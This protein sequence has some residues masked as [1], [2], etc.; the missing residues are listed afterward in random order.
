MHLR[1]PPFLCWLCEMDHPLDV[2]CWA[3]GKQDS[4]NSSY[5]PEDVTEKRMV[6]YI[7]FFCGLRVYHVLRGLS[8]NLVEVV[9]LSNGILLNLQ[10]PPL[11]LHL[12]SPHDLQS[13]RCLITLKALI[14]WLLVH[15]LK[16]NESSWRLQITCLLKTAKEWLINI[17]SMDS[18]VGD[19]QFVSFVVVVVV[20]Y[21]ISVS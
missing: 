19:R 17:G 2:S 10:F 20:V 12:S 3:T 7:G 4:P 8:W 6:T 5:W 15:S 16:V 14:L 21:R 18:H 9:N 1:T 13:S 11:L